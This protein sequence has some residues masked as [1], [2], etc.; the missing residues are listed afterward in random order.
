MTTSTQDNPIDIYIIGTGM[1]GYTQLTREAENALQASERV[2][3]LDGQPMVENHIKETY[4]E[5]V[6][7]LN[8]EYNEGEDRVATYDRM[9]EEVLKGATE[10]D[11]P[12][13]FAL[14]GHPMIFVNPSRSVIRQGREQGLNV[15]VQPG[16]SA[17]DCVYSDIAF[18]PAANGVQMFEA[19][20]LL[21]RE[22]ELNPEVPAMIWQV[23]VVETD[24]H[25]EKRSKESRF[26][27]FKEYLQNFYPEDHT[28]YLL[29]TATYPIAESQRHEFE[30]S[31]LEQMAPIL[32]KGYYILHLPPINERDL[33]NEELLQEVRS[34]D[35]LEE[36]TVRDN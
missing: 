31:N 36:I 28:G 35:H 30:I 12:I 20:D 8:R 6:V 16:I 29:Q 22:W 34:E 1:V 15:E 25:T 23:S 3:L 13:T 2:Y 18:D 33:Q 26:T 27:R 14:Y 24:R 9:S 10:V 5:D 4:T 32:D 21:L 17:I 11:G 19:T 7:M